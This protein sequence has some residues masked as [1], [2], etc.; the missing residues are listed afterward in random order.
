MLERRCDEMG[1]QLLLTD[2]AYTAQNLS[3]QHD[4]HRLAVAF[5]TVLVDPR[6]NEAT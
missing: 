5:D 2:V 1:A 4:P 3:G 6:A